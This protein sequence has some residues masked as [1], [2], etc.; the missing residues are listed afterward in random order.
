M[1]SSLSI[2]SGF[3]CAISCAILSLGLFSEAQAQL[4]NPGFDSPY[5]TSDLVPW[6]GTGSTAVDE[7]AAEA[8]EIVGPDN[9]INPFAGDQ[10]AKLLDDGSSLT[11]IKQRVGSI[12]LLT[13]A[14]VD[15]GVALAYYQAY[16]NVPAN[17]PVAV[18]AEIL[19]QFLDGAQNAL[20]APMS[21]VSAP[22][23]TDPSSWEIVKMDNIP[24]PVG[25]R[26]A[27]AIIRYDVASLTG[28]N[29]FVPGYVDR[30]HLEFSY[31]P[32]PST[33]GL[34]LICGMWKVVGSRRNR[35]A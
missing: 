20:G 6:G 13:N 3:L 12:G 24:V 22:L 14:Q 2:K 8:A 32:E 17:A 15:T 26:G 33:F 18:T 21:L 30:T 35:V 4:S 28:T 5:S 11:E 27:E 29:G 25:A 31:V 1:K 16:L 10:M 7:W 19:L 23:D 9:G 34:L